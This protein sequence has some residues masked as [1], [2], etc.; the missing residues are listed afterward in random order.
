MGVSLYPEHGKD[1]ETLLRRAVGL[2]AAALPVGRAGFAN[3]VERGQ[4][5]AANDD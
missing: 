5:S 4:A 2:A 3:A 1:A